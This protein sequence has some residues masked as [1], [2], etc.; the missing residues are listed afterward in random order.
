LEG[1]AADMYR[2]LTRFAALPGDTLVC[3]GHEYT[4]SNARFARHADPENLDLMAYAE[5][6][7]E[8]RAMGLP[9]IPSR[10]A[11][12]LECNPFLRAGDVA[13]L[14]DL[15]KRKDVYR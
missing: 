4:E 6:V 9:T 2:S 13:T 7:A 8:L 11:D 14:A 3:C 10:L 12:E 15:R 1:T 5:R